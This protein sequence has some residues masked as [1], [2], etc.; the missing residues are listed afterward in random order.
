LPTCRHFSRFRRF[1]AFRHWCHFISFSFAI[2]WCFHW[3]FRFRCFLHF[4]YFILFF[5]LFSLLLLFR[6]FSRCRFSI[7]FSFHFADCWYSPLSLIFDYLLFSLIISHFRRWAISLPTLPCHYATLI[8]LLFD[9][10]IAFIIM[11]LF[12]LDFDFS[13]QF[14]QI[15]ASYIHSWH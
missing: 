13:C 7:L 10:T 14:S 1:H 2:S 11:P 4:R 8:F 5:A 3:Y 9:I 6:R 15:L 12:V